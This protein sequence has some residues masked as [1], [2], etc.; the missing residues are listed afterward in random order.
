MIVSWV[1]V[2]GKVLNEKDTVTNFIQSE[3]KGLNHAVP[4][5]GVHRRNL[6][7]LILMK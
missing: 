7:P 5:Q 6:L 2:Y 1:H 3:F 4:P